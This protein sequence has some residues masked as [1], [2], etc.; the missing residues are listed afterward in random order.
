M[1]QHIKLAGDY[2][3]VQKSVM[4]HIKCAKL[5][6]NKISLANNFVHFF[7]HF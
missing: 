6:K 2:V 1:L 3:E 5:I 7:A 4:I